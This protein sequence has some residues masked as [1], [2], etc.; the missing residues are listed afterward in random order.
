M[1]IEFDRLP[2]FQQ[3]VLDIL[4]K[5]KQNLRFGYKTQKVIQNWCSFYKI[6]EMM[7]EKE[8]INKINNSIVKKE[9]YYTLT[10]R[11]FLLAVLLTKIIDSERFKNLEKK[12]I[13]YNLYEEI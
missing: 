8:L 12:T 2:K 13:I 11:G 5:K 9:T 6:T 7:V 4:L 3:V 1:V 10:D